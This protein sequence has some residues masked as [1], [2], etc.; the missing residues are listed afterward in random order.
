[1]ARIDLHVHSSASDGEHAP[2][3]VARRAAAAGLDVIAL[4]DHD[5]LAG[6]EPAR[7][8]GE[9]GLRVIAGCEFS[10][11]APWGEM[12]LLA[13]FL[14]LQDAALHAFL[15]EQRACRRA[16]GET[17]VRK[18]Q[19]LGVGLTDA[20]VRSAAGEGAVGRPHVARALIN[21]RF[22]S[23]VTEAFDRYL[24]LG[25]PAYVA[26]TLPPLGAVV[27]LVRATGGV[28]A[29]AHLKERA[30]RQSLVA[31]KAAGVD[32]VEVVHPAHD[33][34]ARRRVEEGAREVG[35]L[36][37]GGSDWHG[38]SRVDESRGE[39]GV[40]T[41]P[42]AWLEAIETLHDTRIMHREVTL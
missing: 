33:A 6:V 4:T 23:N 15:R 36:L 40:L 27:D 42:E 12:H 26:K 10:V 14:P 32:A 29:A 8:A 2:A 17:I 24:G 31:L 25:R 7:V 1:V 21:R 41:V 11:A 3:E 20:D 38:A 22:V 37:T 13:Y 9:V 19:R 34:R 16:R 18:L 30:D 28:S 35:M 39:L 5:T